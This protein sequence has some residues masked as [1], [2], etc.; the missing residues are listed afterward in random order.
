[1]VSRVQFT[2][3]DQHTLGNAFLIILCALQSRIQWLRF[4]ELSDSEREAVG[5]PT[6]E[7]TGLADLVCTATFTSLWIW[8]QT[9][10]LVLG[11][12]RSREPRIHDANLADPKNIL[13]DNSTV[14]PLRVSKTLYGSGLVASRALSTIRAFGSVAQ[15]RRRHTHEHL[16]APAHPSADQARGSDVDGGVSSQTKG[17]AAT[18]VPARE[19]D[20]VGPPR[21]PSADAKRVAGAEYKA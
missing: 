14:P 3:M 11:Y 7:Y 18:T 1:M 19:C 5:L 9:R 10:M 13:C 6:E 12:I 2:T 16:P 17:S 21:H 4:I 15:L 8:L 20:T